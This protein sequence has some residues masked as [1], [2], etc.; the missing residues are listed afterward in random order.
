[1]LSYIIMPSL[2]D[3]MDSSDLPTVLTVWV[4]VKGNKLDIAE[5]DNYW[6][7]RLRYVWDPNF[8]VTVRLFGIIKAFH[9]TE[10]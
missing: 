7:D 8:E 3:T 2:T 1:M 9:Q 10:L 6:Q 4:P 5:E